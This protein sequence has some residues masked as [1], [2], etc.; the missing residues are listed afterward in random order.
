MKR[1]AIVSAAL[2]AGVMLM[3]S[4]EARP[5]GGFYGGGGGYR[6]VGF[7]GGYR[8]GGVGYR[9]GYG[10]YRG[11]GYR[12]GYGGLGVAAGLGVGLAAAAVGS[13]YYADPYYGSYG[14]GYAPVGYSSYGYAPVGYG[15]YGY[16][17][18]QSYYGCGY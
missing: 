10:G 3:P 17:Y 11:Y 4:A 7:R 5:Y 16:G 18:G 13:S 15:D 12:R 9:G 2:L 14:Y 6:G 8:V 1:L